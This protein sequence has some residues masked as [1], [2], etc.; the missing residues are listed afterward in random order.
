MNKK[1]V[2]LVL[3]LLISFCFLSIVVAD[4]ATHDDNN[5]SVH[6]KTIIKD[7]NV[8]KNK[9]A[10]KNK[11]TDKNKTDDKS[12]N[13]YILAKGKG[14]NIKFSDGFKGFILDYSKSPANSGDEFKSFSTSKV[15]NSNTLKLAIIECYK[16]DSAEKIGKIMVDFVKTR[17]NSRNQTNIII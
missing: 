14:N 5:L 11:T 15:G 6:D 3:V 13:N 8:D 9:T 2:T 4:N 10:D 7:K 12:K 17:Q 1:I 16:Q